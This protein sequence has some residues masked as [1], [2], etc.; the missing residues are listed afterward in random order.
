[1]DESQKHV[2]S[3]KPDTKQYILYDSIYWKSYE[4]QINL[5]P[6][7]AD[8][9]VVQTVVSMGVFSYVS[10]FNVL[11]NMHIILQNSLY[12]IYESNK[13]AWG[14]LLFYPLRQQ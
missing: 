6:Q 1:M 14:D 11:D 10:E 2:E 7:K 13:I 4:G 12:I 3:K 5:Y 8:Q 9:T